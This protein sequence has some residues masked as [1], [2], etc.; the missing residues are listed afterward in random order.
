MATRNRDKASADSAADAEKGEARGTSLETREYELERI[1]QAIRGKEQRQHENALREEME[2]IEASR[3]QLNKDRENFTLEMTRKESD[4]R[5]REQE[6]QNQ[7]VDGWQ[8]LDRT[9]REP[10]TL[11]PPHVESS[12]RTTER[13]ANTR[14]LSPL[15]IDHSNNNKIKVS[16]REITDSVPYFDGYNIP[17]SR[18]VRA[19]RRAKEIISPNAERDLTKLLINK[20]GHR[21]YYAVEDEPCDSIADLI[22]L[23]T[24]AFGLPK[25]IDQYRGEL[26]IIFLKPQEHVL[27]Y[28]SR[29][30]ELRTAI[31]DLERRE[32]R[33][34]DPYFL[35]Q[36]DDL[37]A[38]SF[39][40][41]LPFEYRIQMGTE[42]RVSHTRAFATAKAISKRQELDKRREIDN[43]RDT[44]YR[45]DYDKTA[46]RQQN[47]SP[48]DQRQ[49]RSYRDTPPQQSDPRRVRFP[50]PITNP[51]EPNT[52]SSYQHQ[53]Q[54]T[55][56]PYQSTHTVS[57]SAPIKT[58]HYCKK[59]GH[60]INECRRREYNNNLRATSQQNQSGPPGNGK[61]SSGHD[62]NPTGNKK[63]TRPLNSITTEE[64]KD[65]ITT[66]ETLE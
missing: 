34:L 30:K 22:D 26:S 11:Q 17:L 24:G 48:A 44:R 27:D 25:T 3:R 54:N 18:F 29:V 42:E 61:T 47:A 31:I 10:T 53:Y 65:E 1:E 36:V 9:P 60:D 15:R 8:E 23:L 50:P 59:V 12:Y 19:C 46:P 2:K 4:L 39:I 37:T 20:L 41:G 52:R 45:A 64:I 35:S 66:T 6:I 57:Q 43:R 32:K 21:A 51:R 13:N 49:S 40:D 63:H 38:R 56:E 55:R 33:Y 16:F 28:I 7:A 58:C 62:A 5:N 14:D